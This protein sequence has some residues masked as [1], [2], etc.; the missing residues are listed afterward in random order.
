MVKSEIKSLIKRRRAQ[1]IVH[2]CIYYEM[3]TNV[4]SDDVWQSWADE[5]EKLQ[6]EHPD[7]CKIS[8]FDFEFSDWT[9]A[10]GAH[11]PFR[12][13]WVYAKA[14]YVVNLATK[15]GKNI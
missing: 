1:V 4:V 14:Q 11:L 9:G 12:D 10:T 5:L 8:F 2:S 3:N 13:P 15:Y 7:C 6:K